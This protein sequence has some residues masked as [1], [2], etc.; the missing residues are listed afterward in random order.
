MS[1]EGRAAVASAALTVCETIRT[2]LGP[3]GATK[4]VISD[5]GTVT[6]TSSGSVALD[7][8]DVD[9]P[10]VT[11]LQAAA[12][13]FRDEHGDGG[14]ALVVLTGALL[15]EAE[16]LTDRGLHPTAIERGYRRALDVAV[17][18]VDREA[19][20]VSTVGT[21]ALARTALTATRDPNVHQ[22]VGDYLARVAATLTDEPGGF[23]PR[24]VKVLARPGRAMADTDLVG[25]VVLHDEPVTEG[26]SRRVDGGVALL[27]STVDL[28]EV[29]TPSARLDSL[30]VSLA[31][32]SFEDR[33]ALGDS[34]REAFR[35]TVEKLAD[36]GCR[37]LATSRAVNDRVKTVLA[38]HGVLAVQRVD[39]DDLEL[40]ARATGASV[41]PRLSD[42]AESAAEDGDGTHG[43]PLGTATATVRRKAGR[44]VIAVESTAGEPVYTVFCRAPDPRSVDAFERSVE[45][46]LAMVARARRE[47]TVVPAGGAVEM[48]AERAVREH[49]RSVSGREQLAMEAF[50]D[51]LTVV[52]RTL[53]ENAGGDGWTAVIRLRTAHADGRNAHGVDATTGATGDV[54]DGEPAVV[55]TGLERATLSAATDLSVKL[56][57]I[58]D[59]LPATELNPERAPDELPE[60]ALSGETPAPDD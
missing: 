26:M 38:N 58:D 22:R 9:H 1:G 11:L 42:A 18:R 53:T 51:A 14:C 23:D 50:A 34:E 49:A 13:G 3:F 43:N 30:D 24:R 25:G 32:E 29:G 55:P 52:P 6:T 60:G 45:S 59:V 41:V 35:E 21:R 33:A 12:E 54:T 5:D 17:D 48:S 19:R 10:S 7:R 46:A 36:A 56:I 57:R 37:F 2:T 16:R 31:S 39:D 4:L 27:S 15:D 44:D 20:P 28:A 47:G 40:L 8:L